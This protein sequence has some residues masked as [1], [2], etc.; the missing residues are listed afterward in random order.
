MNCKHFLELV[1][2][3]RSLGV[4]LVS[5]NSSVQVLNIIKTNFLCFSQNLGISFI[6]FIVLSWNQ[7]FVFFICNTSLTAKLLLIEITNFSQTNSL[8]LKN[9]KLTILTTFVL[10]AHD[11]DRID[12]FVCLSLSFEK[13]GSCM[14]LIILTKLFVVFRSF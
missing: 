11:I 13:L 14:R 2:S 1:V 6:V 12:I 9:I 10:F 3:G 5:D 4:L 7:I 8:I